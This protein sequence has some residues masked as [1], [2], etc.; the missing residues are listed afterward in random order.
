M[1]RFVATLLAVATLA[2]AHY[3]FVT[4]NTRTGAFVPLPRK[5]DL[6][7]IPGRTVQ[8]FI[9]D[10][11][12]QLLPGDSLFS[13]HSQIRLAAKVWNDV[14]TSD[15]RLAFGGMRSAVSPISFTPSIE[16]TFDD[17]PPGA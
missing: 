13:L 7:A 16:V 11:T 10:T 9:A 12:P 14:D 15:L 8:F 6:A 3:P 1:K 17:L 5:F 2:L 4:Y